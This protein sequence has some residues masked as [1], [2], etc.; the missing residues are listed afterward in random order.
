M[1]YKNIIFDLGNVLVK[2]DEDA[3]MQA[4][5]NLGMGRYKHLRENPET[6]KLFQAMGIGMISNQDFF[7]AFRRIVNPNA[8]DKQITDA[9][10]AILITIPDVKKQK[11][12]DLRKAGYRTFLLSNTIDLHW[13]YCKDELFPMDNFT[14][15]DYFEHTFTS[16]KMHMKKPDD[17]IFQTVIKETGIE[18]NDTIF[19]DDLEVNCNAAER[20]GIHAFQNKEFDDW[21]KLFS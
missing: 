15:D 7:N 13:R 18:P 10:N 17:E 16:Q 4:F 9:T 8:T 20:N 19:I 11:L 12:M 1:N 3:T 14:V 21:M 2:L 5:E 6:L